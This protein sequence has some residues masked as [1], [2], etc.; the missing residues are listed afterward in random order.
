MKDKTSEDGFLEILSKKI[1]DPMNRLKILATLAG[2][3]GVL[4]E[5]IASNHNM[6]DLPPKVSYSCLLTAI[7]IKA[8]IQDETP[9]ITELTSGD[10]DYV[11]PEQTQEGILRKFDYLKKKLLD[12]N[13]D[14]D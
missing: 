4:V 10:E 14:D 5:F 12:S 11:M 2:A 9:D 13:H 1:P 3:A 8:I 6:K 7:N